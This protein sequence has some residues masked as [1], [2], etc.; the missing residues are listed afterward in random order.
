[1]EKIIIVF[2]LAVSCTKISTTVTDMKARD[3]SFVATG[4]IA[5]SSR[6][7][8]IFMDKGSNRDSYFSYGYIAQNEIPDTSLSLQKPVYTGKLYKYPLSNI[9]VKNSPQI[10][11]PDSD[12]NAVITDFNP[13]IWKNQSDTFRVAV[14]QMMGENGDFGDGIL[15]IVVWRNGH[16]INI[17]SYEEA[18]ATDLGPIYHQEYNRVFNWLMNQQFKKLVDEKAK[19]IHFTA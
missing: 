4:N 3:S 16:P 17:A 1:M 14:T 13:V 2:L 10:G 5:A 9:N 12:L 6:H 15:R 11:T 7:N 18:I 19:C 8:K